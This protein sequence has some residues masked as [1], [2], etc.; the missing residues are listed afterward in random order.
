MRDAHLPWHECLQRGGQQRNAHDFDREVEIISDRRKRKKTPEPEKKSSGFF[1]RLPIE[2]RHALLQ[3]A[4]RL[5]PEERSSARSDKAEHDAEKLARREE[6]VQRLL[7]ATVEK[8][9]EALELFDAFRANEVRDKAKLDAALRGKSVNDKLAE[10]RRQIEMRTVALGW[11]QFAPKWSYDA[12]KKEET[13]AA[14]RKLLLE[15]IFPHE[16]AARRLKQVPKAAVPPQVGGRIIKV[17]GTACPDILA[18]EAAALFST[19]KL[20][21]RAEAARLRREAAGISDRVEAS[22]PPRP[23]F[24]TELVGRHLEIC[25]PYKENGKTTKIWAFGVVKRI[26]DGINDKRTSRCSKILP[27]GALLWAWEKQTPSSVRRT[28]SSGWSSIR[29]SSTSM[30]STHGD[31]IH[32]R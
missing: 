8:Y 9:A 19:D 17:L 16:M 3:T 1:W 22:Q 20:L 32:A 25:W 5:A 26:A 23:A 30:C 10:L 14:W 18:I 4:R 6:A 13:V 24:N 11:T 27:A 31:T 2:A 7:V 15:E 12:D 21:V 29:T 28:G